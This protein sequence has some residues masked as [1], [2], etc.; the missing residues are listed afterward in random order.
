MGLGAAGGHKKLVKYLK[1]VV[2]MSLHFVTLIATI[3]GGV[4]RN[5]SGSSMSFST[6][7]VAYAATAA[8]VNVLAPS[9]GAQSPSPKYTISDVHQC[10]TGPLPEDN[11]NSRDDSRGTRGWVYANQ[12]LG[13]A[14]WKFRVE[15]FFKRSIISCLA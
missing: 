1:L 11:V 14:K 9:S 13:V 5:H 8:R 15:R 2:Q 3:F 7:R 10:I 4:A 12:D 6:R